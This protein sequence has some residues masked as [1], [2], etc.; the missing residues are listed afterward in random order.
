MPETFIP[1]MVD[2]LSGVD[3]SSFVLG[4]ELGCFY[5]E[6]MFRISGDRIV[7]TLH[8]ANDER[9]NLLANK[10]G[11]QLVNRVNLDNTWM[12]CIFERKT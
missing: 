7:K 11:W 5:R 2:E 8:R 9:F 12:E 3:A 1:F 6:V 4:F 10:L